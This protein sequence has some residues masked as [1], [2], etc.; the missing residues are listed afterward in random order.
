MIDIWYVSVT[1][2]Y[3]ICNTHSIFTVELN[4]LN[5]RLDYETEDMND[6][7]YNWPSLKTKFFCDIQLRYGNS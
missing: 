3:K 6:F 7:E 5:L 2:W 1:M 4:N